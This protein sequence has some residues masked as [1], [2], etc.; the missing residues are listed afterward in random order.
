MSLDAFHRP[1]CRLLDGALDLA[2]L[3]KVGQA[4]EI[5]QSEQFEEL[6]GG[7]IDHRTSR[8]FL[9][10]GNLDQPPFEQRFEY[11]SRVDAAQLFYLRA[12][13]GLSIGDYR[14]GLHQ[15]RKSVGGA[16]TAESG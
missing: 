10:P 2:E 5:F 15:D 9:A 8:C 3:R 11:A 7:L 4:F 14:D 13:D 1:G 12:R 16:K 6:I